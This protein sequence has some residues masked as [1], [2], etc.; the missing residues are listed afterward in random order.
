[1]N[2]YECT[3]VTHPVTDVNELQPLFSL[4]VSV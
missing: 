1:V 4:T 3:S 2:E